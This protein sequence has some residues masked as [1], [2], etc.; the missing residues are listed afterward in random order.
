MSF[1][2]EEVERYARHLVLN[3]VGG[4]GQAKLKAAR[5]LVLGAGGLGTPVIQYLAAAGVGTL[6]LVDE[7]T[8]SLSNLQRQIL[9]GVDD[10]GAPKVERAAAAVARLNPHV[11]VVTH[12]TRL[13]AQN[14]AALLAGCDIAVDGTDNAAARYDLSDAAFRAGIPLISA[15]VTGFDGQVTTFAPH[16]TAPDGTPYP[17]YRCLYPEPPPDAF[18][19]NCVANGILG[20]VTGVIGTIE[21][22]EVL[23]LILG[24]GEPLFETLLLFDARASRFET[25]RYR[26]DPENPLSGTGAASENSSSGRDTPSSA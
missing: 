5:V 10:I 9:Y 14:A 24:I 18:V 13:D 8:V 25:I 7:D 1:A 19:D 26:W 21:A 16:L 15:A 4:P 2:P 17:T 3:E 6:V 20:V 22:N 12:Q 11:H 23:K